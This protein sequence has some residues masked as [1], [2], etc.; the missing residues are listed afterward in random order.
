MTTDELRA[1]ADRAVAC[2][3]W[4]W[5]PGMLAVEWAAP[6]MGL[7]GAALEAAP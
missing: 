7:T 4:R 6:G 3:G 5:I 2:K 1:L